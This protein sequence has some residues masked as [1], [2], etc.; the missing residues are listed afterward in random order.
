MFSVLKKE[1]S[2][3]F[4]LTIIVFISC[5][6]LIIK[7]MKIQNTE[8]KILDVPAENLIYLKLKY[9]V[10]VIQTFPDVAPKTVKRIKELTRQGFYNNNAFF[11]VI[12]GFV[13]QTGDPSNT[14]RGGSGKNLNAEFS[15][16]SHKRGIVSMARATDINSADSQFFIVLQDSEFLDGKYTVW[17]KVIS[18]M[19]FVDEIK[20]AKTGENGIVNEPDK[21]VSMVLAKDVEK[22]MKNKK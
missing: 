11:R 17:G 4:L 13:A 3:L 18:G 16:I 22:G 6:I 8:A 2:F 19:E 9:G 1:S 21:I 14:G 20:K 7:E 12:E 15:K 10:V 5:L